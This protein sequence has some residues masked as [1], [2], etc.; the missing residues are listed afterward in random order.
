MDE[1]VSVDKLVNCL[2]SSFSLFTSSPPFPITIPGLAVCMVIVIVLD[3]RLIS[4]FEIPAFGRRAFK[5][6]RILTSPSS[7][8]AKEF[9]VNHV[10]FQFLLTCNLN[11]TGCVF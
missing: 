1:L 4:T 5:Y 2:T 6:L 11:P 9:S 10:D 7:S 8:V 3:V